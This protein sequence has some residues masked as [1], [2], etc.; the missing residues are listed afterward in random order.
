MRRRAGARAAAIAAPPRLILCVV[1]LA[2]SGCSTLSGPGLTPDE[3]AAELT[4]VPFYPDTEYYC[5]PAA[6]AT[7]LTWA[8]AEVTPDAL[9]AS[10]FIPDRQGT[11]QP[12]L[13]ARTR[14]AER[15]AYP[16]NGTLDAIAAEIRAGHPVLVLQNLGL[17]W[18]PRWHYAVV[19][20]I[21]PG[22]DALTLRSGPRPRYQMPSDVFDATWE[23]SERWAVVVTP[24]GVLP[25]TARSRPAFAASAELERTAGPE[26]ALP[27]WR[28]A[29][30]RWPAGARHAIGLANNLTALQRSEQAAEVLRDAA[31]RPGPLRGVALNN[32]AMLRAGQGEL[33][34]AERLARQAVAAGGTHVQSFRDTLERVRCQRRGCDD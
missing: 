16:L 29:A 12:E 5:G 13:L 18:W 34:A 14:R 2:A 15:I 28:A 19:V 7:V 11:L 20:G 22:Q 32:L 3:P 23:R 8:G 21:T 30:R 31:G 4:G 24:P 33:A 27:Y 9:V 1:L 6:L 10:L 26:S 17:D 25:A